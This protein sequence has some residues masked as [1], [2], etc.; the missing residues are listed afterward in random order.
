[1]RRKLLVSAV[2]LITT[3][4]S[5]AVLAASEPEAARAAVTA[6]V[7]Q[8]VASGEQTL[9]YFTGAPALTANALTTFVNCTN[10]G[11]AKVADPIA[12]RFELYHPEGSFVD[13][14]TGSLP[15]DTDHPTAI[16]FSIQNAASLT[17]GAGG[18]TLDTANGNSHN[19]V[20]I[21]VPKKVARFILCD[22]RAVDTGLVPLDRL[23][24]LNG[25]RVGAKF[26][27]PKD[28]NPPSLP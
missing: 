17:P 14:C 8:P 26:K 7:A 28:T 27:A 23:V 20:R 4:G 1:M 9:Y 25:V 2:V 22:A 12:V 5:Q 16:T 18:C 10:F 24:T 13:S 21:V 11:G 6:R 3:G 19:I 15:A